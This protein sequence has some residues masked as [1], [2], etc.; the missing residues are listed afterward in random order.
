MDNLQIFEI[1]PRL[2]NVSV[3]D[4]TTALGYNSLAEAE[5]FIDTIKEKLTQA[6]PVMK[7][8]AGF[9]WLENEPVIVDQDAITLAQLSFSP[10]SIITSSLNGIQ[11]ILIFTATLGEDFDEWSR[12]F[13][14]D[15]DPFFGYVADTI[16]SVYVESAV[17]RLAD[18]ISGLFSSQNLGI[19]NRY[20]PGYCGWDVKEQKKLFSLLPDKFCGISLTKSMMMK[21]LK[22]VSGILGVGPG[23]SKQDYDCSVCEKTSCMLN[24]SPAVRS[25][26][27]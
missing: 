2:L 10:G 14:R 7:I 20:S 22:S 1:D 5:Q 19:S 11:S 18:G 23:L 26:P 8:K 24:K 13:F 6:Q 15:S 25:Q 9:L 17:D 3:D 16:G 4:I 12:D 21:P 27:D